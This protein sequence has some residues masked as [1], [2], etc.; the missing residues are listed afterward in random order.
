MVITNADGQ[1]VNSN[2]AVLN[3]GIAPS[4]AAHPADLNATSG[5][6]ITL[7]VN[8]TGTGPLAYQWQ[9]KSG[10]TTYNNI[11]GA[12]T[13]ALSFANV[14]V[15]DSG[16]YR[17]RVNSPYGTATSGEALLTVGNAPVLNL[18]PVDTNATIG[19]TVTFAVDANG[20]TPLT[21]QW[22]KDGVDIN[23]STADILTLSN[24]SGDN[25]GTYR[26]IVSNAFG[27]AT[28]DGAL[29]QVGYALKLWEFVTEGHVSSSPAITSDGM[30]YVGSV[31][32]KLYAINGKTGVKLWEFETGSFVLSSPAIGSDGTV[33]V[34][35][36]EKKIYR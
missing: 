23:G 13:T 29:L 2:G 31:D 32:K 16:T 24:L 11:P 21:Y 27:T 19:G 4:I 30:V 22:Q 12:T 1:S 35:S 18:Q 10:D 5:T 7:D 26:V 9:K 6:N 33:Y 17:V 25:N 3:V 15:A 8:A 36:Y 20:T 28:G 14:Q 34:G